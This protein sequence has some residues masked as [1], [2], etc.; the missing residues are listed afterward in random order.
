MD[1]NT[2][3]WIS[4]LQKAEDFLEDRHY[5]VYK[6]PYPFNFLAYSSNSGNIFVAVYREEPDKTSLKEIMNFKTKNEDS[7]EV[8]IYKA[9]KFEKRLVM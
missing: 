2:Y 5:K 3:D 9:G 1:Y 8:W 4:I 7:K 6:I